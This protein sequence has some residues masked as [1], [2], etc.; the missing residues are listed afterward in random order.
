MGEAAR[1]RIT[2]EA[3]GQVERL[4]LGSIAQ[5]LRSAY[6]LPVVVADARRY[7]GRRGFH[8]RRRQYNANVL[9]DGLWDRAPERAGCLVGITRMGIYVPGFN[10]LFGLSYIGGH[11]ALVSLEPLRADGAAARVVRERA[12]K[13]AV[14][15]TGHA[16][17]LEHCRESGCVMNYSDRLARLDREGIGFGPNCRRKLRRALAA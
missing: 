2:V 13:I 1:G 6:G 16:L 8:A 14:H 7:L 4:L 12:A 11:A 5:A 3:L 17:G 15:E 9:L 10:F